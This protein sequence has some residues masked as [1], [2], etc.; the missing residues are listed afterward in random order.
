MPGKHR[1]HGDAAG[2][3]PTSRPMASQAG[4]GGSITV[5]DGDRPGR[6]RAQPPDCVEA[7]DD[8][9]GREHRVGPV[10]WPPGSTLLSLTVPAPWLMDPWI[11]RGASPRGRRW[12]AA[13]PVAVQAC[14]H[15]HRRA[16]LARQGV[17][18]SPLWMWVLPD[19]FP[20]CSGPTI[21]CMGFFDD[22][23]AP[24]PAHPRVRA[25][26]ASAVPVRR[27][28]RTAL[29]RLPVVGLAGRGLSPLTP[30]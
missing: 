12:L 21:A 10:A 28:R 23:P 30:A 14:P 2:A 8:A 20:A 29:G 25:G 26:R 1:L 6:T 15:Q 19:S 11:W 22:L 9:N 24:E 5:S 4:P 3:R 13:V 16:A 7:P 27:R 18:L 17:D